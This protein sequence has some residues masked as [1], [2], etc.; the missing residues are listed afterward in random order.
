MIKHRRFATKLPV[1]FTK[2]DDGGL[3]AQ[4]DAIPGFY[5]SAKDRRSVIDD[6]APAIEALVKTNY[7]IDVS[8]CPLGYGIF[9]LL[10]R[11]DP[12]DEEIPDMP[13]FT[14]EYL[15]ERKAA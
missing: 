3:R 5:L 4:C 9:Q 15:V 12:V 10:E 8:V 7:S 6:V 11:L 13:E 2:R 14:R 1:R